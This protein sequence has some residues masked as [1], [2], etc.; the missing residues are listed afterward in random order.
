MVIPPSVFE[1]LS[2]VEVSQQLR[3]AASDLGVR[4]AQGE[5]DDLEEH[6]RTDLQSL[7]QMLDYWSSRVADLEGA[8][9]LPGAADRAERAKR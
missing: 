7:A 6:Q 8:I 4:I 3:E 5:Y 1:F 9:R 2:G